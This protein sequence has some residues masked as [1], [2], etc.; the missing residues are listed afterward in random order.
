MEK[1]YIIIILDVYYYISKSAN[2][3][4]KKFCNIEIFIFFSYCKNIRFVFL[5]MI[6]E[7]KGKVSRFRINYKVMLNVHKCFFISEN[8]SEFFFAEYKEGELQGKKIEIVSSKKGMYFL[9]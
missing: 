1:Y 2:I 3:G 9:F 6:S 7:G 8:V 5:T 4:M